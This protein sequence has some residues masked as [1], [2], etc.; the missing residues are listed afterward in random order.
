MQ[1]TARLSPPRKPT[2]RESRQTIGS[3]AGRRGSKPMSRFDAARLRPRRIARFHSGTVCHSSTDRLSLR[4]P[5]VCDSDHQHLPIRP[6]T[7]VISTGGRNLLPAGSGTGDVP[8]RE[9][10]LAAFPNG[11]LGA[12]R[13]LM[14]SAVASKTRH[15]NS[16]QLKILAV[17][18]CSPEILS[19]FCGKFVISIDRWGEGYRDRERP[20]TEPLASRAIGRPQDSSLHKFDL[21]PLLLAKSVTPRCDPNHSHFA[22]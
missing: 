10:H 18:D 3:S 13:N 8:F 7:F 21:C 14:I 5:T 12:R 9:C 4:P 16:L 17:S 19:Q 15:R 22:N 2:G 20:E 11:S 1:E 6:P